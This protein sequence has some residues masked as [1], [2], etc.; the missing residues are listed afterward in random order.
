MPTFQVMIGNQGVEDFEA[1]N[2]AAA[3]KKA[4]Q[5]HCKEG[6][7]NFMKMTEGVITKEILPIFKSFDFEL[8]GEVAA[9]L[10][11]LYIGAQDKDIKGNKFTE[12]DGVFTDAG[13]TMIDRFLKAENSKELDVALEGF[14][15]QKN[16]TKQI[17]RFKKN[18]FT[19]LRSAVFYLRFLNEPQV[20]F[21]NKEEVV[22][23]VVSMLM[24]EDGA[25]AREEGG[26]SIWALKNNVERLDSINNKVLPILTYDRKKIAADAGYKE[27]FLFFYEPMA[28]QA[29]FTRSAEA[30]KTYDLLTVGKS[31][32]D[33]EEPKKEEPKKEEPKGVESSDKG[34]D[35]IPEVVKDIEGILSSVS[36][37]ELIGIGERAFQALQEAANDPK[38]KD[39]FEYLE[40][41]E[42]DREQLSEEGFKAYEKRN[43]TLGTDE[44][45]LS[46]YDNPLAERILYMAG[47]VAILS[48]FYDFKDD[49]FYEF[50]ETADELINNLITLN[51]IIFKL[52]RFFEEKQFDEKQL[53]QLRK[54][55]SERF[56]KANRLEDRVFELETELVELINEDEPEGEEEKEEVRSEFTD[57]S[58]LLKEIADLTEAREKEK[59]EIERVKKLEIQIEKLNRMLDN[60]IDEREEFA[61]TA[62]ELEE[63]LEEARGT[64]GPTVD[65]DLQENYDIIEGI[66]NSLGVDVPEL[67]E[68]VKAEEEDLFEFFDEPGY[69]NLVLKPI[70][71]ELEFKGIEPDETD[72][73]DDD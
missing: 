72:D 4:V 57:V 69:T 29:R 66:L 22:E 73:E 70:A 13:E 50:D 9:T 18:L 2:K 48:G 20:L 42:E 7:V 16:P 12:P 31:R 25:G 61:L 26:G 23:G 33:K 43:F 15:P 24:A 60:A 54:V 3:Y 39:K 38:Y 34:F 32:R 21:C 71:R 56:E 59:G 44:Y 46:D 8:S 68:A 28:Y 62:R 55:A 47:R 51:E 64:Q 11:Y 67:L 40:I 17:A 52:S 36:G 49:D 27:E 5:K 65:G 19:M 6:D 41:P 37:L 1:P 14:F 30:E 35:D 45:Y 53:T 58:R 10:V 63:Q